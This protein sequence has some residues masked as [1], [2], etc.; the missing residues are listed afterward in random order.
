MKKFK[1]S[2]AKPDTRDI[3]CEYQGEGEVSFPVKAPGMDAI[4]SFRRECVEAYEK[5]GG[6]PS[7]LD[8]YDAAYVMRVNL[9][10]MALDIKGL[11]DESA[12]II[13]TKAGGINC[14]LIAELADRY[15]VNDIFFAQDTG[16]NL[17]AEI[18]T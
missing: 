6:N 18:P 1:I 7:N 8:A 16:G 15:G 5:L 2:M 3:V 12:V 14:N 10:K 17:E 4:T 13:M 11:T 9:I